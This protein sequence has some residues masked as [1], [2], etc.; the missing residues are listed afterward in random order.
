[1]Y[2]P[3]QVVVLGTVDINKNKIIIFA[4]KFWLDCTK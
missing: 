4:F 1:M 2:L 3:L